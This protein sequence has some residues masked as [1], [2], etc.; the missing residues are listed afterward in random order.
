[1]ALNI[2]SPVADA[3]ARE[4]AALADESLTQAV[5]TSL[6]QRLAHLRARSG[7]TDAAQRLRRLADEYAEL[8]VADPRTPDEIIGYDTDGLP[9]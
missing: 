3:L 9:T 2:K 8:T 7:R 6:E 5:V 1:M 4:V